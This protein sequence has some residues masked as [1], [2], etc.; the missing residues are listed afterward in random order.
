[1]TPE[2]DG[3]IV[4]TAHH[5]KS[6][7]DVAAAFVEAV[8]GITRNTQ[9]TAATLLVTAQAIVRKVVKGVFT[10][11]IMLMLSA[12]LLVTKDQVIGFFRNF[13]RPERRRVFDSLLSRIDR[14]LSGVVRG[15]LLICLI[16]GALSGIG[17]YLL[18]LPYWPIL[19]LIATLFSVIP[20]FG[21]ILSSVPAVVLGLQ[22]GVATAALVVLWIV[23]IHQIEANLLNPKIMG[24]A[25]HVHPVLV[26]FAL[27]G[28]EHLFGIAGALLAVPVLSIL[29]SLFLHYREQVLGV[30][31]PRRA[32]SSSTSSS[33]TT[34]S[35]V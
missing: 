20:I 29:Q 27:L 25:A 30:P 9:D 28:G 34:S 23:V 10:F 13:A 5:E 14:G 17:F 1:M 19:T 35:P 3:Y 31:A 11:F 21:A 18:D 32:D 8:R 15:Q 22:H 26:V 6:D 12:Y 7:G 4:R 2:G 33:G 16:N 24:D